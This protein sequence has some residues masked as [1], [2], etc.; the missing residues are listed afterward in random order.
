MQQRFYPKFLGH[1][2]DVLRN[3]QVV[4][5]RH[6]GTHLGSKEAKVQLAKRVLAAGIKSMG[7]LGYS[8]AW[9]ISEALLS[10]WGSIGYKLPVIAS[11]QT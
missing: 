6:K 10:T 11:V 3:E 2:S 4:F 5:N 7:I 8:Q 9:S 1:V